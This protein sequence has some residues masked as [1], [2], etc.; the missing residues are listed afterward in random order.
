M[1]SYLR[2]SIR[3]SYHL[4]FAQRR[5]FTTNEALSEMR[6]ALDQIMRSLR[7]FISLLFARVF[8][9]TRGFQWRAK[10]LTYLLLSGRSPLREKVKHT[11]RLGMGQG[12]ISRSSP[13]STP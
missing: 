8:W 9:R 5:R 6:G 3:P 10:N 2:G 4:V 1:Q 13:Y 7:W 12:Q 11:R